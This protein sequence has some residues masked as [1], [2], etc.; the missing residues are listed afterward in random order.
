M[1]RCEDWKT[2]GRL[3]NK[4]LQDAGVEE[5]SIYDFKTP[6]SSTWEAAWLKQL[7]GITADQTMVVRTAVAA[8]VVDVLLGSV[9]LGTELR[10]QDATADGTYIFKISKYISYIYGH[11]MIQCCLV[12]RWFTQSIQNLLATVG[13][14]ILIIQ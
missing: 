5:K 1:N 6:K 11:V 3:I 4:W 7:W 14:F 13:I 12:A 2:L 10:R 9:W 8:T